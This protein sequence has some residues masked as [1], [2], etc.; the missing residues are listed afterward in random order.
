ML[1]SVGGLQCLYY[2]L[3]LLVM[4]S[5]LVVFMYTSYCVVYSFELLARSLLL[6]IY[7]H[8]ELIVGIYGKDCFVLSH[9]VYHMQGN[10]K[11]TKSCI[12]FYGMCVVGSRGVSSILSGFQVLC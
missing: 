11:K 6:C 4:L 12:L 2:V 8:N 5:T 7:A 3:L 10:C 9:V 1:L